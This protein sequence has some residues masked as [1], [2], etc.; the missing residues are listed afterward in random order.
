MVLK[1]K[2]WSANFKLETPKNVFIEESLSLMSKSN[3]F[4]GGTDNE[5]ELKGNSKSQDLN[6]EAY[7]NSINGKKSTRMC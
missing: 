6:F 4:K 5:N 2:N 3:S 1:L 7:G